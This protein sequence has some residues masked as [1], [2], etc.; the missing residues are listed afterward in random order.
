MKV[1]LFL[2]LSI[3]VYANEYAWIETYRNGGVSA[4]EKKIDETLQSREYW[5]YALK[6]KDVRYGYYESVNFL[7]VATKDSPSLEKPKLKL[8]SMDN[9]KWVEKINVN[10]LVGSKGG[11]KQKEGDLATPIGVYELKA[12]LSGLDQYYGPLAYDTSYPN[13]YDKLHKRTGYGI[14]IHGMPLNGNREELN[15]RG[16][17]AIENNFLTQVDGL[18]NHKEALLIT[19]DNKIKE[20]N[21]DE[22]SSILAN[23]FAWKEAWK[24]ND[25]ESY[26]SFYSKDEFIRFDGARF[27]EFAENKRRI[28]N[29]K[30]DKT[31]TFSKINV[32]P[33]PNDGNRN[34]FRISFFEDYK[35]PSYS[36]R[37]T[38][39]LY[40][41]LDGEKIQILAEK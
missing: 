16:C 26:L 5:K 41:L 4:L 28:F 33:Y 9:G 20:T 11:H 12:R 2:F 19:Y 18:I 22:L 7:F 14:W 15:T 21:I 32:S 6:D 27:D 36:F 23:L 31:I 39:E 1:V 25:I 13:L 40:V 8:Y 37:G 30:E 3:F 17:I 10:S 34:M 35:A 38:K 29:K 24:V